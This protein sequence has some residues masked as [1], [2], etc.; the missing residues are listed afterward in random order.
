L[1]GQSWVHQL[2]AATQAYLKDK[3]AFPQGVRHRAAPINESFVDWRPDQRLSFY[4]DLVPYLGDEY[5]GWQFSTSEGWN[6]GQNLS[7]AQR[8]IPHLIGVPQNSPVPMTVKHPAAADPVANCSFVGITGVGL[9]S[10]EYGVNAEATAKKR[11]VFGYDRVTLKDHVKDGLAQTI[12]LLMVP[13]DRSPSPWLAGGGATLRGVADENEDTHP[14]GP[15][16]CMTYKAPVGRK[17]TLDGKRGTL[18]IMGDGKVRFIPADMAPATFRAL[19][20]IAGDDKVDRL[21]AVAPVVE[22]DSQR[23]LRGGGGGDLPKVQDP[24]KKA[25]EVPKEQPKGQ[26]PGGQEKAPLP[27]KKG[28]SDANF[29]VEPR[30][31]EASTRT[32]DL[33][34][35]G[36][37]IFEGG[38]LLNERSISAVAR[39]DWVIWYRR[40]A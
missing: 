7:I 20:T 39:T 14:L 5:K 19:C 18:A 25:P 36:P 34:E 28:G 17:S 35:I 37:R 23:E 22:D 31:L 4:A 15:F 29:Q 32:L 38:R 30:K 12:V 8:I 9:D 16:I 1:T 40:T 11:G 21:D 2:A 6:E 10:A 13:A 3:N 27:P 26:Q 24:P 33:P